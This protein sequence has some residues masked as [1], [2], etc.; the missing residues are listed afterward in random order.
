MEVLSASEN[1]DDDRFED[2]NPSDKHNNK[3]KNKDRKA[4][5]GKDG[6]SKER[7][8]DTPPMTPLPDMANL[9]KLDFSHL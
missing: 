6:S 8:V 2:M 1:Y 9:F 7:P 4:P 3:K 5:K